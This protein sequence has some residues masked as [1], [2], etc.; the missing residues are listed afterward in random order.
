MNMDV[1]PLRARWVE[2]FNTRLDEVQVAVELQ[3]VPDVV[4]NRGLVI[5][6]LQA[7]PPIAIRNQGDVHVLVERRTENRSSTLVT[8][9]GNVRATTGKADAEW[10][11]GAHDQRHSA[12]LLAK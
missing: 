6:R 12:D 10:G 5:A 3:A 11:A 8:V 2:P 1:E 4:L 7:H 9:W